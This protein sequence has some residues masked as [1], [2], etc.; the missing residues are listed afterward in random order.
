MLYVSQK[1]SK[2]K[3]GLIIRIIKKEITMEH[4]IILISEFCDEEVSI[5][6]E[7]SRD[8]QCLQCQQ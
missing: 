8:T 7:V 2:I 6:I 1:V 4:D 3:T 5:K